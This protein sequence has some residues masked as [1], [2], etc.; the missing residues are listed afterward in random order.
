MAVLPDKILE[1]FEIEAFISR[2]NSS[3]EKIISDPKFKLTTPNL[4]GFSLLLKLQIRV[5][6]KSLASSFAPIFLGKQALSGGFSG[7]K[8]AFNGIKQIFSNPLQFV[9]DEGLNSVLGEFPFPIRFEIGGGS[10]QILNLP[11]TDARDLLTFRDFSYE[12]VFDSSDIPST[13]QY[14][15]PQSSIADMKEVIIN[16][17]TNSGDLNEILLDV[18]VGDQIQISDG[19]FLGIYTVNSVEVLGNSENLSL[20]LTV[21][22]VQ[23]LAGEAGSGS[24]TIPGFGKSSIGLNG[25][26][27]AIQSFIDPSGSLRFPLK[28]LGVNIPLLSSLIVSVGDFSKLK[29]SSPAKKYVDRLSQETGLEFQD[30]LG[31][32]LTGKFPTLDFKKIQEEVAD[33]VDNSNEQSKEDLVVLA[34]V[35]EIA[36]TNPC[37]L[38][39]IIINYLKLLLLPVRVVIGVIKGLASLISGPVPLIRT[40]I[41]G[42]TDPIGLICD[43]IS[44]AFLE[45]I[46]PYIQ[47]PIIAAG[48]PWQEALVDPKDSK[49]GLQPLLSDLV[50][51]DFSRKLRDYVPNQ[52]FFSNLANSINQEEQFEQGPQITY[53]LV[54]DARIPSA[55]QIS[56]NSLDTTK[57]TSFKIS[58]LSNTVENALPY[59]TYLSTGDVFDF[60]FLDR[61]GKYRIS[62]KKFVSS[63]EAPYFEITTTPLPN[64]LQEAENKSVT[65]LLIDGID[66]EAL[67]SKLSIDNPDKE[68]LFIVE[69]YLPVKMVA[70][71]ESIKGVVALFGGLAQQVPSLIPAV[72]RS[73]FGLNA[74]KSRE[75]ILGG[76]DGEN[77]GF[78]SSLVESS[79]EILN[80]LYK[81]NSKG[82]VYEST[83]RESRGGAQ[84]SPEARNALFSIIQ[85]SNVST[86][87]GIETI[88]YDL[89]DILKAEGKDSAIFR[90]KLST[91]LGRVTK[92]NGF[93]N[94]RINNNKY[95]YPERSPSKNDFYWGAYGLKDVGDSVKVMSQVMILL[96]NIYYFRSGSDSL[97]DLTKVNLVVYKNSADGKSRE[98]IY[99]G[100]AYNGLNKFKITKGGGFPKKAEAR[101]IRIKINR[102]MDFL[103]HYGLPSLL[104]L[105]RE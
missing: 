11:D 50:C 15:T 65:E 83:D 52:S 35:L 27:L 32:I 76:I 84:Y 34:R 14:T 101:D 53:D 33:G 71:W 31:G 21:I 89:A 104:L 57:I 8:D 51:G 39:G 58:S 98:F 80:L 78:S 92:N 90:N 5:F 61:S 43:L 38:I 12:G 86:E 73:L 24:T 75:Q 45:V 20:D 100:N 56:V 10:S 96:R 63:D 3:A 40:V 93:L 68:F 94:I 17:F 82:L 102:E 46:R 62:S 18:G 9:L 2:V 59:L 77:S 23:G 6:E 74:G 60:Q 87:P 81:P 72:L 25:C 44:K 49:R 67:K 79:I 1:D 66:T 69:K 22:S 70:V 29:D 13:G 37:F 105:E 26:Q 36:A 16:R 85:N 54:S 95:V 4:P 42:I 47:N 48:I 99:S 64:V 41:K 30:V 88:F 19:A 103:I 91:T 97:V 7:I 28:S 55:G